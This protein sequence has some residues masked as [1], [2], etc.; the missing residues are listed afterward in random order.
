MTHAS[1]QLNPSGTELSVGGGRDRSRS[2]WDLLAGDVSIMREHRH[3][4]H[5]YK[6][7]RSRA[8]YFPQEEQILIMNCYEEFKN[9]IID[10]IRTG[11]GYGKKYLII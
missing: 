8:E 6:I 11:R 10:I 9:Q 1:F 5:L 3:F 4:T 7:D 2:S